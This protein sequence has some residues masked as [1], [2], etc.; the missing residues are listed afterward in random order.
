MGIMAVFG[1]I[2][3]VGGG[4]SDAAL[5]FLRSLVNG[6]VLKEVG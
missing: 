5:A 2:L 3:D 4:D 1:L 6:T